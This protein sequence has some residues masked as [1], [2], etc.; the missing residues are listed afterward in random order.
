MGGVRFINDSRATN[1]QATRAAL[2]AVSADA[3]G[4]IQLILG[5]I[6][7]GG[8]FADLEGRLDAVEGIQA[9]GRTKAQVAAEIRSVPV[10]EHDSLDL[11]IEHAFALSRPGG[12]VLLSPG[13]SS[14]DLFENYRDRGTR[15]VAAVARLAEGRAGAGGGRR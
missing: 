11:A 10:R 8:R 3:S 4:G 2:D 9:I 12:I 15:F 14:F 6:L 1:L 13:C 7:K 5:G